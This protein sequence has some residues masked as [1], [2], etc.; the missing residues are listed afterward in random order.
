MLMTESASWTR[1]PSSNIWRFYFFLCEHKMAFV[2]ARACVR[3]YVCMYVC[4]CFC[5]FFGPM[6]CLKRLQR[7]TGFKAMDFSRRKIS[8]RHSNFI[9]T[10]NR[11]ACIILSHTSLSKYIFDNSKCKKK[12]NLCVTILNR[13]ESQT[14]QGIKPIQNCKHELTLKILKRRVSINYCME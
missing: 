11:F 8:S 14:L 9:R 10:Q 6:P 3:V 2:C 7:N 5:W 1:F 12:V 13:I 4:M